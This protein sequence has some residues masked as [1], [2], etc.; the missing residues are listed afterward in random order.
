MRSR[1]RDVAPRIG[2]VVERRYLTIDWL[3]IEVYQVEARSRYHI[4]SG[5]VYTPE[6]S[7]STKRCITHILQLGLELPVLLEVR[8]DHL[9]GRIRNGAQG[10]PRDPTHALLDEVVQSVLGTLDTGLHDD[11]V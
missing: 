4:L 7:T 3:Y 1:G 5:A 8:L 10:R 9:L 11:E 6:Y 2:R